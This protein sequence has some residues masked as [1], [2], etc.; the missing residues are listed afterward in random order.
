MES[1]FLFN[2]GKDQFSRTSAGLAG[3]CEVLG[4]GLGPPRLGHNEVTFC[5]EC[6]V[7]VVELRP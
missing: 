4:V 1:R 3:A 5:P 7:T 2:I 6:K